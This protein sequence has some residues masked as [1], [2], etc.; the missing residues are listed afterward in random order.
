MGSVNLGFGGWLLS[1]RAAAGCA[2]CCGRICCV[3]WQHLRCCGRRICCLSWQDSLAGCVILPSVLHKR[4]HLLALVALG[5]RWLSHQHRVSVLHTCAS[6]LMSLPAS[7]NITP[8]CKSNVQVQNST[9]P[10][11][12]PVVVDTENKKSLASPE[13]NLH[14]QYWQG[15]LPERCS[16]CC[17][18][19]LPSHW[20]SWNPVIAE[21]KQNSVPGGA[22]LCNSR[23]IGRHAAL[24]WPRTA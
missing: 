13:K 21:S 15:S 9:L 16:A 7:G 8:C 12:G 1:L 23:W 18:G 20:Q 6:V 11:V 5:P 2:V 4:I 10:T 3:L 14:S 19:V 17:R 24:P 22:E